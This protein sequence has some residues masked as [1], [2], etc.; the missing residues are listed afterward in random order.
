MCAWEHK[1]VCARACGWAPTHAGNCKPAARARCAAPR[2]VAH[3]PPHTPR[4]PAPGAA[5]NVLRTLSA[6]SRSCK[7]INEMMIGRMNELR[8]L[9]VEVWEA[10]SHTVPAQLT[11]EIEDWQNRE[12]DRLY[13]PAFRHGDWAWRLLLCP[14]GDEV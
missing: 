13:S 6:L 2:P 12:G 3:S 11:W 14:G 7:A 1:C 5:R 8:G 10:T 4:D 9:P